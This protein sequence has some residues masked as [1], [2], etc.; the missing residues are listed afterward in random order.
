[1][2]TLEQ[3]G[4]KAGE[5]VKL[6]SPLCSAAESL[7]D[8]LSFGALQSEIQSL[9]FSYYNQWRFVL[10]AY[11]KLQSLFAHLN[12]ASDLRKG[13][14]FTEY[15]VRGEELEADF[16]NYAYLF[17]IS[18]KT[19]M[20]SFSCLV[21]IIQNQH[22]RKHYPDINNYHSKDPEH[23]VAEVKK[24]FRKLRRQSWL[25]ELTRLRNDMIHGGYLLKPIIGFEKSNALVMQPFKGNDYYSATPID[26][27][28]IFDNFMKT[29]P[30]F[31]QNVVKAFLQHT[32]ILSNPLTHESAFEFGEGVSYYHAKQVAGYE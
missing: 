15:D 14:S 2:K 3:Y 24:V 32:N 7:A 19:V 25:N 17:V 29:V 13:I 31:E 20:D 21:D 5:T 10:E 23:P 4:I 8:T 6:H 12:A 22:P 26:I 27:G 16:R 18:M 28:R 1:M 9:I 11:Q 30:V